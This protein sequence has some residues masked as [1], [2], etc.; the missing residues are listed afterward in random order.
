MIVL[1]DNYDSFTYNLVQYL[2]VLGTAVEVFRN[3]AITLPE[4]ERLDPA[5]IVISPGPGRPESAGISL[6][7]IRE[8]SGRKP[9]LGVCLGHQSIAIAFGGKVV[10]AKRLMHG[11]T[12]RIRTDGKTIYQGIASPITAMRYHSLVVQR[13]DLPGCLEIT[14]EADDG[15]IMGIRHRRY[16]VE[17]IQYHPESIMTPVGKRVLRNFLN[18]TAKDQ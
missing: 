17:G 14:A 6:P 16:P 18:S 8:F 2:R 10:A 3:D 13:E 7:V 1:I 15:E 9:I 11:K 12:S 5:G 4:I